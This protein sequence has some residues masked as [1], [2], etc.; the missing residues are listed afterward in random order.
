[1]S[2]AKNLFNIAPAVDLSELE[3]DKKMYDNF[4]KH[5]YNLAGVDLPYSG[6]NVALLRNRIAKVLRRRNLTTYEEYWEILKKGED[7]D[8]QEFISA[9][10]TNM[11][12]FFRE[13]SH[14]DWLAAYL[15][16][17]FNSNNELRVWCAAAST[18]QEP[19]TIAMV[20][21]ENLTEQQLAKVKFLA[22][23]IDLE[24]LRKASNGIYDEKDVEGLDPMLRQKYFEPIQKKGEKKYRVVDKLHKLITF[25]Q[26]NLMTEQYQFQHKFNIIFCRNVLI[27]FDEK[28]T[29]KV[30]NNL[31]LSVANKG[32]LILGHSESGNVKN[33]Y[34]K[35]KSKA[36]YE[37]V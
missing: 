18:G 4:A 17:H 25:A 31:A 37:K 35:P 7:K 6:K 1:M 34:L 3:L 2:A 20:L 5:M 16:T 36:I 19:Y 14:F 11:T 32:H 26:F 27:Y 12:S 15:K 22:T 30:I 9:L 33:Q 8:T 28:T 24:V 29:A 21:C 10:T 13:S 23:D